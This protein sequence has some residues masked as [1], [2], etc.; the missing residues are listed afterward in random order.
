MANEKPGRNSLNREHGLAESN[1]ISFSLIEFARFLYGNR[2]FIFYFS[3]VYFLLMQAWMHMINHPLYKSQSTVYVNLTSKKSTSFL[4]GR[5]SSWEE[6]QETLNK[7][8]LVEQSF[9]TSNYRKA[10]LKEIVGK[11]KYCQN[12]ED[13]PLYLKTIHDYVLSPSTPQSKKQTYSIFSPISILS[14]T[15]INSF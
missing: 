14:R 3:A 12:D 6:E 7:V 5:L 9:R 13:C 10:L 8:T 2:R 11:T 15:K 1:S 4:A